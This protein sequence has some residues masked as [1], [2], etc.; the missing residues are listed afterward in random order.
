MAER[1]GSG[2]RGRPRRRARAPGH[3]RRNGQAARAPP[4]GQARLRRPSSCPAAG[5]R[6]EGEVFRNPGLASAYE[7]LVKGGRDAYYKGEIAARDRRALAEE[8]GALHAEDFAAH[9]SEWVEPVSTDYRGVR[10]LGAAPQRPGDRRAADAEHAGGLTTCAAMGRDSAEFWHLM[11]EAKKLAYEDR[12]RF[13]RRPRLLQG[14]VDCADLEG[15][16]ARARQ[17]HRP[18]RAADDA[19]RR[20]PPRRGRHHL[21]DRGRQGR[22]LVSLIQSNYSRLRLGYTCRR[23]RASPSRTAAPLR[24][25]ARPRQPPGAAQAALPHDHPRL[26]HEGRQALAEPSA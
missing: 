16:R 26:R 2:H 23:P 18:R 17:L 24:L 11:I 1:P 5:R 8:R 6:S 20:R 15:L 25:D 19:R 12:A 13:Y 22:Q 3:R 4:E 9:R 7:V 14:P 10:R 21:P